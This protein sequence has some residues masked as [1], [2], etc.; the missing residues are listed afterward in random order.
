MVTSG[1]V[2]SAA[3]MQ[4]IPHQHTS[5]D[6]RNSLHKPLHVSKYSYKDTHFSCNRQTKILYSTSA[7]KS[8]DS[9]IITDE[10][11]NDANNNGNNDTGNNYSIR[12][13]GR[14]GYID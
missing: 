2:A 5:F 8:S 9:D 1:V 11:N 3:F 6:I 13:C 10:D 12:K 14:G 7:E 4:S